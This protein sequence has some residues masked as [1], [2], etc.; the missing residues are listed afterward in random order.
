MQKPTAVG[1]PLQAVRVGALLGEHSLG[2]VVAQGGF[3]APHM[4]DVVA[5][6]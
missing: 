2:E 4:Q 6:P 3:D 5:G 1:L